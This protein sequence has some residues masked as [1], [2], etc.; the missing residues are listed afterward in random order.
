MP[1]VEAEA[2]FGNWDMILNLSEELHAELE[3]QLTRWPYYKLDIGHVF[4]KHVSI[5]PFSFSSLL[6]IIKS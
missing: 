2:L 3:R 6:M 5:F 4:I 1:Q